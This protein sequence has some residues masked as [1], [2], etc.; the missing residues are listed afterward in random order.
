MP[1]GSQFS[2]TVR[3]PRNRNR[4]LPVRLQNR[5]GS[6]CLASRLRPVTG[7]IRPAAEPVVPPFQN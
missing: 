6:E 4:L 7:G 3:K 5:V 2:E 1:I